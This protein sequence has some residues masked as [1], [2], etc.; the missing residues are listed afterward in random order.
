M[1]GTHR[2]HNPLVSSSLFNNNLS[3]LIYGCMCV[4]T[5]GHIPRY[6]GRMSNNNKML[7][8]NSSCCFAIR[9]VYTRIT[10]KWGIWYIDESFLIWIIP[11]T[12]LSHEAVIW[13]V[14]WFCHICFYWVII[15]IFSLLLLLLYYL[16]LVLLHVY[17][18]TGLLLLLYCTQPVLCLILH[19][20]YCA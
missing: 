12:Y 18:S 13:V 9:D 7:I 16:F 5:L 6:M 10:V 19:L 4:G 14:C 8:N 2:K 20:Y 17:Y 15:Q 3:L 1:H 11:S